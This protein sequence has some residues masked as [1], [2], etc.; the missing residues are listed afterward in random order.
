VNW[1]YAFHWRVLL[2]NHIGMAISYV[3][4][5]FWWF[6]MVVET[7][8]TIM[9]VLGSYL[10]AVPFLIFYNAK[11]PGKDVNDITIPKKKDP[12]EEFDL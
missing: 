1:K 5:Y 4:M 2:F 12:E 10:I 3:L 11:W 7:E 9:N 8:W 6:P